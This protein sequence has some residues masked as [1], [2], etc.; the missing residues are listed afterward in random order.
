M[1]VAPRPLSGEVVQPICLRRDH[2]RLRAS[3]RASIS[4]SA[5]ASRG[6]FGRVPLVATLLSP[7]LVGLVTS[8]FLAARSRPAPD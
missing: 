5:S 1:N 3:C 6:D 2:D 4:R 8:G 7:R